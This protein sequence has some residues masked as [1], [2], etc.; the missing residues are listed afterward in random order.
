MPRTSP[1]GAVVFDL[2][3]LMFNTEQ[4][5][6]QVGGEVLRRRGKV[7]TRELLDRMIGRPS[8]ISL[9]VM[10]D[11]HQLDC[12]VETL[13]RENDEIFDEILSTQLA[14]MR[15]LWQL[16]ESLESHAVPKAI[17]TSSRRAFVD[18]V[19]GNFELSPRFH[20]IL[21]SESVTRGK[22]D[23]EIYLQAASRFGLQPSEVM[24]L[25]DSEIGCRAA[26]ASGAMAV[27]VPSEHTAS[28]AFP[29][30]AIVAES[31]ADPRIY[32]ALDIPS[33]FDR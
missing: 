30:A 6:Q 17:G 5:Y 10:I 12:D 27:A 31:L 22:P 7:L 18:K 21:T 15:G 20:F 1:I 23:P 3:G 28:H 9:Q 29:G 8:R 13:Q 24:V 19:L 4:L 25:E 11:W 2:D 14:P 33:P 26:V 32:A 16:L